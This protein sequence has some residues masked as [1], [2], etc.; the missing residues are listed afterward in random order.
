[1]IAWEDPQAGTDQKYRPHYPRN[2]G[3]L[4]SIFY[5]PWQQL[6]NGSMQEELN[7]GINK[8]ISDQE[9]LQNEDAFDEFRQ[10]Q[11][12][13]DDPNKNTLF[14]IIYPSLPRQK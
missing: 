12:H 10:L 5:P 9:K 1:M 11:S 6:D 4:E 3:Y 7:A 2:N 13:D 8:E 14:S